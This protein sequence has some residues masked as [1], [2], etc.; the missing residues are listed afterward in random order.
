VLLLK[1]RQSF[2]RIEAAYKVWGANNLLKNNISNSRKSFQKIPNFRNKKI[3][4][5]YSEDS[6]IGSQSNSWPSIEF[7]SHKKVFIS[8]LIWQNQNLANFHGN[9]KAGVKDFQRS[10]IDSKKLSQ[11]KFQKAKLDKCLSI[12]WIAMGY[13]KSIFFISLQSSI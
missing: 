12:M 7:N 8:C 4:R 10:K 11:S 5:S 9:Q 3:W 6:K 13:L 1:K 2:R